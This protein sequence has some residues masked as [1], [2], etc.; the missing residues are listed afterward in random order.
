MSS[1]GRTGTSLDLLTSALVQ[2]PYA[3]ETVLSLAYGEM[4][5]VWHMGK[6]IREGLGHFTF[7]N[8]FF[9]FIS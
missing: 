4:Q 6:W 2:M 7:N 5:P 8:R 9:K 3:E 1:L